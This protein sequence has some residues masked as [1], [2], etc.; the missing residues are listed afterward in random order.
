MALKIRWYKKAEAK[1]DK[2]VEYLE[3]EWGEKSA[4][5]LVQK[6]NRVLNLIKVYPEL[7]TMEVPHWNI[8][9]VLIV[10]QLR[11]FYVVD[12]KEIKI[13]Q[14]FDTRKSPRRRLK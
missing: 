14:V 3:V 6:V 8:R 9:G 11:I 2:I 13:I 10:K 4:E 1:F 7:G 12:K 5:D